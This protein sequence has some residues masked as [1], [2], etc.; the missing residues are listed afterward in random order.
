MALPTKA[1]VYDIEDSN[2]ALLG[3]DV[4]YFIRLALSKSINLS[5]QVEKRVREHA[6]N[7]EPAWQSA[8]QKEGLQIWRIE[9][10]QVKVW[11]AERFGTF[12]DGDSY[13]VLYVCSFLLE[14]ARL[15]Y[16][17]MKF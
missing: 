17:F 7:N 3:S 6:G 12:Y 2:I 9:K 5:T 16:G 13:I 11:P 4:S 14:K 15:K 10:F 1:K 8:G